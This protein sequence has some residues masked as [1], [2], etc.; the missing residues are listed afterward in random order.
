MSWITGVRS[1]AVVWPAQSSARASLKAAHLHTTPLSQVEAELNELHP[2][3]HPPLPY[4]RW[5][6]S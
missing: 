6:R 1:R 5:R 3:A 4:H 2:P